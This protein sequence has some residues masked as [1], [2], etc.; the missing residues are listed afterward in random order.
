MDFQEQKIL[1]ICVFLFGNTY[2]YGV[3]S[4]KIFGM[5]CNVMILLLVETNIKKCLYKLNLKM[6][7]LVW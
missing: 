5:Q 2:T 1:H 3:I 7:D 4:T 6:H